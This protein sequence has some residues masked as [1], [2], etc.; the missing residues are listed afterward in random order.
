MEQDVESSRVTV[1]T[2]AESL[3]E[4]EDR[5]D[6][7]LEQ[8]DI[9]SSRIRETSPKTEQ[10]SGLNKESGECRESSERGKKLV[11]VVFA[12]EENIEEIS[13][14][15]GIGEDFEKDNSIS[16]CIDDPDKVLRSDLELS[17][18][19]YD[20]DSENNK[21]S[22]EDEEDAKEKE[23]FQS[24]SDGEDDD[25]AIEDSPP[26]VVKKQHLDSDI[27]LDGNSDGKNS[28]LEKKKR[29]NNNNTKDE[30]LKELEEITCGVPDIGLEI[31]VGNCDQTYDV[32]E[33]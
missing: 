14:L 29:E 2:Q 10:G 13:D 18:D 19:D 26:P 28:S 5:S 23:S 30:G 25:P 27:H 9:N 7:T 8:R 21:N 17:K 33:F 31:K 32:L 16:N 11:E 24:S 20:S 4:D 22:T 3:A 12:D 1:D 15:K 6:D